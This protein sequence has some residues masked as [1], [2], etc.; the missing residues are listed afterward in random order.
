M[1]FAAAEVR[2][3]VVYSYLIASRS[4]QS[5]RLFSIRPIVYYRENHAINSLYY[6]AI[7]KSIANICLSQKPISITCNEKG[8]LPRF[9]HS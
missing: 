4:D 9:H 7:E 1:I 3:T 8:S 2:L 6:P 5:A